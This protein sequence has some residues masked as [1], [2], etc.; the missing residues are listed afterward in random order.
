VARQKYVGKAPEAAAAL[1]TRDYVINTLLPQ[2]LDQATIDTLIDNG[3]TGYA[4]EA[5]VDAQDALN[6]TTAYVDAGDATRLKLAQRN[7]NNGVA[8][9]ESGGR[10]D[11]ARVDVASTQR[12]PQAFWSPSSYHGSPVSASSTETTLYTAAI[13]DPGYAYKLMCFG[14]VDVSSSVDGQYPIVRVRHG[15]TGGPIVAEGR[16]LVEGNALPAAPD[17]TDDF[18]RTSTASLGAGWDQHYFNGALNEW[19]DTHGKLATPDGHVASWIPSGNAACWGLARKI[20]TGATTGSDDQAVEFVTTGVEPE[21]DEVAN[22]VLLRASSD[23]QRFV[24]LHLGLFS[25]QFYYSNG[26]GLAGVAALGSAIAASGNSGA[27]TWRVTVMG[28]SYR[29]YRDNT[30]IGTRTSSAPSKGSDYRGWGVGMYAG[31]E[32]GSQ[33]GPFGLTEATISDLGLQPIYGPCSIV[34]VPLHT[35]SAQSGAAT[36]YV[37]LARNG[38]SATVTASTLHPKLFIAAVP[39]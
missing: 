6:A 10:I 35:Q 16:G 15:S 27:H 24:L 2:N 12:Y 26:S 36:L 20:S 34:P 29:L 23:L 4:T 30:L 22:L 14:I 39:A 38:A 37:R 11:P 33:A 31:V 13:S 28:T 25:A 21:G 1:V 9:L 5:Y 32:S 17:Y 7:A 3:F 8:G 18:E 19:D